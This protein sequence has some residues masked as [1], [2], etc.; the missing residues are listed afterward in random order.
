LC[1]ADH[2]ENLAYIYFTERWSDEVALRDPH[3]DRYVILFF[4]AEGKFTRMFS[5][6]SEIPPIFPANQAIWEGL[7]WGPPVK[8]K[9][10]PS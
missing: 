6:A 5:N 9:S 7:I 1:A 3:R 10:N 4:S 8:K 2:N